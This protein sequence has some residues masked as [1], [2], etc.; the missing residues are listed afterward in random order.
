M[1]PKMLLRFLLL[2]VA[3]ALVNDKV[4]PRLGIA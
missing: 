2:G 1:E 4:V 3:V